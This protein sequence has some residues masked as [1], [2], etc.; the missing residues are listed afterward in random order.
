LQ[1]GQQSGVT[2]QDGATEKAPLRRCRINAVVQV[3][4]GRRNHSGEPVQGRASRQDR[5]DVL[6]LFLGVNDAT[7]P[8]QRIQLARVLRRHLRDLVAVEEFEAVGL[9]AVRFLPPET[10]VD[11]AADDG[12]RLRFGQGRGELR[13]EPLHLY[14]QDTRAMESE[15]VI[16]CPQ[17][18]N[19]LTRDADLGKPCRPLI[20]EMPPRPAATKVAPKAHD[21]PLW[22]IVVDHR[23]LGIWLG[24]EGFGLAGESRVWLGN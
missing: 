7:N 15:P 12:F 24:S 14:S 1:F 5:F 2:A 13:H 6:A 17:A 4:A 10:A 18:Q 3:L 22:T 23:R 20:P 8:Q 21:V 16:G 9:G 11:P 19:K